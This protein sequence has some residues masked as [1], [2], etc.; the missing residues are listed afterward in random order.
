MPGDPQTA[1]ANLV[2]NRPARD[3]G[4]PPSVTP[5]FLNAVETIS[6]AGPSLGDCGVV[7]GEARSAR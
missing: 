3:G 6:R 1:P 2:S 4:P 7:Q 5:V